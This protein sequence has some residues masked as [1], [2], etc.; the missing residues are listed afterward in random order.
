MPDLFRIAIIRRTLAAAALCAGLAAATALAQ[1]YPGQPPG[2]GGGP[3][4]APN[5]M[6]Q[7]LEAQLAMIDRNSGEA[8]RAEQLRR[9]ESAAGRQQAELDRLT[10]QG[11]AMGCD[12]SGFFSIFGGQPAQC[13]PLNNRIQQMRANLDGITRN[14][15]QLRTGFGGSEQDGQRRAVIL[16]LAQNNCGPQYAAAARN[17]GS[18]LDDLFGGHRG[19]TIMTPE[20]MPQAGTYRTLC[21]R[22]CDGYYFPI[23]F[24]T[25]PSRF[26]SD[27]ESCRNLCPAA[28]ASLYTYRNPGEDINQAVSLNGA[29][30]SSLPAAFR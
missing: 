10:Q 4:G 2:Y 27:E 25:V 8:A 15:E 23:S 12:S 29:P 30:Y 6:C 17:A 19:D 21:V 18:F 26:G 1:Y 9:Y 5:P 22:S 24:A 14:L 13:G 16:A 28:E 20:N 11:R 3:Q 7:R